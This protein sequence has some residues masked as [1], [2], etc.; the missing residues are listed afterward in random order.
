MIREEEEIKGLQIGKEEVKLS[1][2]TDVMTLYT[3]NP[4][5]ST[6]KLLGLINE[7]SKVAGYKINIQK[8]V[9]SLHTN[10]E[11]SKRETKK[12]IPFTIAIT[13]IKYLGINS[14]KEVKDLYLVIYQIL[15]KEIEK[16]QISGS[17]YHFMDW[18]N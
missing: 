11:L 17:I 5:D 6:K 18:K 14:T 8:S 4:K 10:I 2:F 15:K 16:I 3:E 12:I 13:K 9:A 7:F 1:L